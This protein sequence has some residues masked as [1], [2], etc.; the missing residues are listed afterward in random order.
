MFLRTIFF[1]LFTISFLYAENP[2]KIEFIV[3]ENYL[4]GH[5]LSLTHPVQFSSKDTEDI[6]DFQKEVWEKDQI[7][8]QLL[9]SQRK[10]TPELYSHPQLENFMNR[11][12]SFNS[13]KKILNQTIEYK[14]YCEKQWNENYEKTSFYIENLTNIKFQDK[15]FK[16]YITH[17]NQTTG[18]YIGNNTICWGSSGPFEFYDLIY[19]WHEILHSYLPPDDISHCVIQFI[20]DNGLRLLLNNDTKT[21][22]LVGHKYLE[23]LMN[24]IYPYWQEYLKQEKH[25]IFNFIEKL[26][27]YNN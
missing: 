4:I 9:P 19:L 27:T 5:T 24:K 6:I 25:D 26:K 7:G 22:P 17:P 16:V 23:P 2:I 21:F 3:D 18:R 15:T 20:T 8:Y 11:V 12:K 1:T 14:N 13:Y 10:M